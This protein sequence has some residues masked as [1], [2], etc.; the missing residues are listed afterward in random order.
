MVG[1]KRGVN[2]I[3]G[4]ELSGRYVVT[5]VSAM[6]D[7]LLIDYLK[8]SH[9]ECCLKTHSAAFTAQEIAEC[10]HIHGRN[11]AKVVMVKIDGELSMIVLPA[12]FHV[13]LEMLRDVLAVGSVELAT[14]REFR[15]RFPRCETGAMPPF[16]HLYGVMTYMVPVFEEGEDIAFNA[17]T[18]TEIVTMP[19]A[20]YLRLAHVMEISSGIMPPG[21]TPPSMHRRRPRMHY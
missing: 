20:E 6:A 10:S 21:L 3:A 5:E 4:L 18:H 7:Q 15:H 11:F 9:A 2:T 16:G 12:H 14:E 13:D 19:Y 1:Q 8:R 17:G